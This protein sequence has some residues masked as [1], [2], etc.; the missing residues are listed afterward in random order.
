M[1]ARGRGLPAPARV[2]RPEDIASSSPFGVAGPPGSASGSSPVFGD[3]RRT[4]RS[5][6]GD[7]IARTLSL[8]MNEEGGATCLWRLAMFGLA[9]SGVIGAMAAIGT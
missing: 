6:D 5:S 4:E 2:G 8:V 9:G 7:G 1:G 3:Q